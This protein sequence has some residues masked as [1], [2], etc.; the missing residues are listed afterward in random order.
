MDEL[1]PHYERELSLLRKY[2]RE[3]AQR[4]PGVAG[5]LTLS[6][7]VADDPHVE[8][9]IEA[10]AFMNA[11]ISKKLEDDYPEFTESFLETIFPHYL[12][13]FPSCSIA[14]FDAGSAAAQLT[15][16]QVIARGTE[17][18]S[19]A[20]RGAACRFRTTCDVV[21]SPLQL[22]RARFE[23]VVRAPDT[24]RLP[25]E[26]SGHIALTFEHLAQDPRP[27]SIA[28]SRLRL[29]IDGEPAFV[30]TLRDAMFM[31]TLR[32]YVQLD[33]SASWTL[34]DGVPLA[35]VGMSADEALIDYPERSHPAYRLL[36]EYFAFPDKFNFVDL[37]FAAIR[38]CFGPVVAPRSFTLHIVMGGIRSDSGTARVLEALGAH[39]LL[40]GCAPIANLFRQRGDPIRMTHA[41]SAY[42]V[43]ADARRA[44]AYEV[45]TIESVK[46]VRQTAAGEEFVEFRPFYAL[47]HGETPAEAGHYW[48]ARRDEWLAEHSPGFEVEI[49]IVDLDLEPSQAQTDT[50]SIELTCCN[51]NL[52]ASLAC[53]LPGGDLFIEGGSS[54][55]TIHLLKKPSESMRFPRGGGAHWRLISHLSL[56]HLSLAQAGLAA[57]KEMLRL[58]DLPRSPVSARHIDG[59]MAIEHK[60]ATAWMPGRPFAT[61]IRGLEIRLTIAESNFVGSGVHLFGAI[62]DE[63]FCLYVNVNSFTQVTLV[64]HRTGLPLFKCPPRNGESTL[65]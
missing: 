17:V 50:L 34:L 56:N 25:A 29:F 43:V 54:V 42:P 36:T 2:S 31:N 13:T 24:V 30:A 60:S 12:R 45:V 33:R 38:A 19:R 39:N 9:M 63:F 11:R 40:L 10:F 44:Y 21:V 22:T 57:F 23:G 26:A 49:S 59:V 53:G 18:K 27:E 47:R 8:R 48:V 35:P 5:R 52:P 62:V 3:F 20:V 14:R 16:P 4:Y 41:A 7:E 64:S 6:G 65:A 55:R 51:R 28:F 1:L 15:A 46:L 58:Y 32:V 37:D 61:I